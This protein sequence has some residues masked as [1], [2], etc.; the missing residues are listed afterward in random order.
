MEMKLADNIRKFRKE[1][2][3]TQEQLAEALGVTAG[4]VYKWEAKLSI[5]EIELIVEMADLF[6]TSV[7]VMLGYEMKDNRFE[8]TVKRLQE[9]RSKKDRRGL[10]EA[11]K[12][13]RKYPNSFAVI[14]VCASLYSGFGLED[15]DKIL[16]RRSLELAERSRLLL[17]QNTD[18]KISEQTIYGEMALAYLGLEE[19]DKATELLK[20]HN[21]GGLYSHRIGQTLAVLKKPDEAL[22]FLSEALMGIITEMIDT[23][24]GYINVYKQQGD[25]VSMQ[26]VLN[27]GI[28]F[29]SS[30]HDGGKPNYLF[31]V[32]SGLYAALAGAHFLAGQAFEAKEALLN[33]KRLASLFDSSPSYDVNE[34]R[35]IS[36]VEGIGAYDDIGETAMGTVFNV[37]NGFKIEEFTELWKSVS[38]K[39]E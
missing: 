37:V 6:D 2:M 20:A 25:Y 31:K 8:A 16:L 39:E 38:G 33:A 1:R 35:F 9:Y 3:L 5:P 19:T 28:G 30:L 36:S 22:P 24:I 14:R 32:N 11:E 17:D 4:A 10:A 29:F 12:A 13:I 26:A 15:G 21:A 18:P 23:V 34:I 7:D 27:S